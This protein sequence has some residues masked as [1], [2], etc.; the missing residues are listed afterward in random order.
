MAKLNLPDTSQIASIEMK[1]DGKAILLTET[2]SAWL[3]NGKFEADPGIIQ[4]L[5]NILEQ[6]ETRRTAAENEVETLSE[7]LVNEGVLVR[8]L[9]KK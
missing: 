4:A 7:R 5:M 8:L 1:K 2:D 9:N 3:V 6:V